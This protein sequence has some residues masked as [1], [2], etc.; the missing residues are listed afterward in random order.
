MKTNTF[1]FVW[2]T[3]IR[4]KNR[5][6][7][8]VAIVAIAALCWSCST[9]ALI[10]DGEMLYNGMKLKVTN[11]DGEKIA[12]EVLS[13]L[14]SAVNVK[15]NN[16]WPLISPYRRTPFPYGLWVYNHFGDS[17][18]GLKGWIYDRIGEAPVTVND[19][20]PEVRLKMLRSILRE[21]GYF[22]NS[23]SVVIDTA[24]NNKIGTVI[25]NLKVGKPYSIDSLEY[26][27]GEGAL[28]QAIDSL[29]RRSHYLVKGE[30]FSVDSLASERV[31]IANSLRNIGYYYF[32]PEYIEFLADTLITPKSVALRVAMAENVPK[33]AKLQ[34]R[35]GEITTYVL[36]RNPDDP[37]IPDTLK[38]SKGDVVVFQPARLS[39]DV[40]P[41]CIRFT[42]GKIFS[43]RDMDR[44]QT[45][46][47]RL[48]MFGN[49][50]I[51]PIPADTSS[52]NPRLN[53]M[54][55]CQFD[56]PLEGVV[57]GNVVSKSN[58][59]IGPGIVASVSNNNTFGGGEKLSLQLTAGYEWQTGQRRSNVFNSYEF[60]LTS[61]L[62]VPRLLAPSFI[63]RSTRAQNWTIF[64]LGMDIMN[65]PHYFKLADFHLGV[66]YEW[67]VSRNVVNQFTPFKIN[68]NKLMNTTAE[69]D[70][71]MGANPAV[72]LSFRDQYIPQMS[73][74]YILDKFLE[75]ERIN[76][77]NVRA[78]FTEGGNL[79]DG[80]Y[81]LFGVKG[82]KRLFGTPFSQFIKGEGQVVYSRRL[83]R[84]ADQ[85]LVS[86]LLVGAAH[87][88][89]NSSV[90]PYAEQFYIGGANSIRAFTV[91]SL[92]PGS[93]RPPATMLNGYFDQTGTFKFEMN[94]EY[95]FPIVS[96]LHG[97]AFVDAGNIWLLKPD[98]ARPGG[99]LK[100]STFLRDIALGTGVGLRVDVGMMVVRGDLGIGL[101]A[102]YDTGI[103]RY[104]NI[105]FRHAFAFHLAIGYPF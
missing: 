75:R 67:R 36:R 22:S 19:A 50:V 25:Y 84:G 21:N 34:Y 29:A 14:T 30:R 96:V 95:R 24:R 63:P 85:W 62:S 35:T 97:A 94:S 68:Y 78:S 8:F 5:T 41:S 81:S 98:P 38:T 20:R 101:H 91:R 72:A 28:G 32:R 104:F 18:R 79:F 59:Y 99:E 3:I 26:I 103:N 6:L 102:P 39:K 16:P 89:G 31:R 33:I 47:T 88:Y 58:S 52:L 44:T 83:V 45:R 2:W 86:R 4:L 71:V 93:Y 7:Q 80:V 56:R 61:S 100:S 42:S 87:A 60:G 48:G 77:I 13:E 23:G 10:P 105:D 49:V 65:R 11:L 55:T 43:V 69:F 57:Q 46:L 17:A 40:I 51:Q 12:P 66:N 64:S 27:T 82:E 74:T 54:I 9:T 37:G 1:A 73:Y 53:V 92:G 90:V 15:P 70:S 76:G